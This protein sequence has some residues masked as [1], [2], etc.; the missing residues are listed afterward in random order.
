MLIA[1]VDKLVSNFSHGKFHIDVCMG[2][3]KK[4]SHMAHFSFSLFHDPLSAC[5]FYP[6]SVRKFQYPSSIFIELK[7]FLDMY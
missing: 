6:Q 1:D 4:I 5:S 7:I 3:P 2:F